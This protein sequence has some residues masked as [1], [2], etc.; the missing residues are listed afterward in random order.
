MLNWIMLDSSIYSVHIH[1]SLINTSKKLC[2]YVFCLEFFEEIAFTAKLNLYRELFFTFHKIIALSS[3][4]T[5][6]Q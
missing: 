1:Q 6:T 4:L 3:Q 5:I 2:G